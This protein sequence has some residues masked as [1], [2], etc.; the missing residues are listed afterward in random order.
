MPSERSGAVEVVLDADDRS[1]PNGLDTPTVESLVRTVVEAE[2]AALR[3]VTVVL[4]DHERVRPLNR[5]YLGHD[6]DTDVLAF[7]FAESDAEPFPTG[8]V[9]DP[10]AEDDDREP[11]ALPTAD[12]EV[13]VDV[14]TAEERHT[15]FDATVEEEIRRYVIHGVLHLL[16]YDDKTEAGNQKMQDLEERYLQLDDAAA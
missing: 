3:T 10:G 14:E 13:Y 4:T 9:Q 11:P 16:G 15:E 5:D 6:Y 12:G 1:F 7:S 2:G 8:D